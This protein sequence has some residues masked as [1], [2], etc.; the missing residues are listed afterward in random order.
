M[1][2]QMNRQVEL[3]REPKTLVYIGQLTTLAVF[4]VGCLEDYY[5]RL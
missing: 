3:R 1:D 5:E 4:T 2:W